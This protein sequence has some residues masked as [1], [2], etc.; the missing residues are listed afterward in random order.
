MTKDG[1]KVAVLTFVK[2][3]YRLGES[4]LGVLEFNQP[5][6]GARVLEARLL[7]ACMH[8]SPR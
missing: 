4:I 7:H 1:R 2:S 6:S 5:G 8:A 3:A